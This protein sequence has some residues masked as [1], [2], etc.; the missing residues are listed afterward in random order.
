M[1][2]II[3]HPAKNLENGYYAVKHSQNWVVYHESDQRLAVY[4]HHDLDQ[5]RY[6]ARQM[7]R[8]KGIAERHGFQAAIVKDHLEVYIP[9]TRGIEKGIEIQKV[10]EPQE[11]FRAL[12]Y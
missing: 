12:G 11:L 3:R 8:M 6:W 7:P 9:W 2:L 5:V 1:T 4:E 10:R